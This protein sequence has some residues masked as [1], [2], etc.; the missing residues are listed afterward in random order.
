[1][2][3]NS[4]EH[5][6]SVAGGIVIDE[7]YYSLRQQRGTLGYQGLR[8]SPSVSVSCKEQHLSVRLIDGFVLIGVTE[9][10]GE[11]IIVRSDTELKEKIKSSK[12]VATYSKLLPRL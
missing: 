8:F 6:L 4:E 12:L 11:E 10:G 5:R 9:N 1:M 2:E 3:R 7:V